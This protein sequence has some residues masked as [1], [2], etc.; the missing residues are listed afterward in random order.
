MTSLPDTDEHFVAIEATK[1]LS[2]NSADRMPRA[3]KPVALTPAERRRFVDQNNR[4]SPK[5]F[6]GT[7][8]RPRGS[9]RDFLNAR[10]GREIAVGMM[11]MCYTPFIVPLGTD[12]EN[13][14]RALPWLSVN[15]REHW[16]YWLSEAMMVIGFACHVD[17]VMFRMFWTEL[18]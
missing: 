3:T 7:D 14:E 5:I 11:M 17:A 8:G 10:D 15:T 16:F 4:L 13:F 1:N 6:F 18:G 2:P 9:F 12:E